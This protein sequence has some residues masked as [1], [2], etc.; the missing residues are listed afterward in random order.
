M[1]A[2]LTGKPFYVRHGYHAAATIM[3]ALPN[4][5]AFPLV[6]MEKGATG[7]TIGKVYPSG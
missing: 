4:G 2:T 7:Q 5:L 6:H 1:G 3:F